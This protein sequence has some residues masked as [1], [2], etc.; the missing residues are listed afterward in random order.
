MQDYLTDPARMK[1]FYAAVRGKVTTPGPARPVFRANTEMMLLTTR[2][3]INPDGKAHIPGDLEVWRQL[4]QRNPKGRYDARLSKA[5]VN[6][7]E[8]DDVIEALFALCRKATDN[9]P[10]MMFMALSDLDRNR[11]QP[12]RPETVQ[13]MIPKGGFRS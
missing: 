13:R 8:P 10:L 9:E 3:R 6:W 1:R 11:A 5:A 7:K 2:L 12:L 4:F